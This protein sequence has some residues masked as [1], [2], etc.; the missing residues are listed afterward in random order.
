VDRR[1][2]EHI[3]LSNESK[4]EQEV[5]LNIMTSTFYKFGLCITEEIV[6]IPLE[7]NWTD[8]MPLTL[9]NIK[10]P[11]NK[12]H[13]GTYQFVY[14]ETEK[15]SLTV[16]DVKKLNEIA[17][18]ILVEDYEKSN[19]GIRDCNL[20]ASSV[21]SLN[22]GFSSGEF[23]Y[24]SILD[25]T[26]HL[27]YSLARNHCFNNGNKRTSIMAVFVFLLENG[28]YLNYDKVDVRDKMDEFL[29]KELYSFT[30][31]I[32]AGNVTKEQ[33]KEHLYDHCCIDFEYHYELL[34]KL[35]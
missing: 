10:D 35:F 2:V 14:N 24:P 3:V 33:I 26:A 23:L 25:K 1:K 34:K 20:L 15:Q 9:F 28:Y 19:I 8:E 29:Y 17:Q 30:K 12:R 22:Q 5:V 4:E 11:V 31:D 27:W 7:L 21:N 6:V 32:A 18:T 16:D 13:I